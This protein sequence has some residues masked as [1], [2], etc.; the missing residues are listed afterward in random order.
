[1]LKNFLIIVTLFSIVSMAAFGVDF[2][3]PARAYAVDNAAEKAITF[4]K[5]GGELE[6]NGDYLEAIEEY[7][8]GVM[9]DE[10]KYRKALTYVV[11]SQCYHKLKDYN[12][13]IEVSQKALEISPAAIDAYISMAYS[14]NEIQDYDNAVKCANNYIDCAMK[15]DN[16]VF[17]LRAQSYFGKKMYQ[18][19]LKDFDYVLQKEP[20]NKTARAMKQMILD[21]LGDNAFA[22]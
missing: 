1:M 19:S 9:V 21:L 11:M 4:Y 10:R 7:K 8:K 13:A 16:I 22:K 18:E 20:N 12:K 15:P 3:V 5:R 6:K 2:F 17:L 14:Y